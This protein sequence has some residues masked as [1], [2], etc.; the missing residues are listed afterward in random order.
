MIIDYY[1]FAASFLHI[2]FFVI[3]DCAP[4]DHDGLGGKVCATPPLDIHG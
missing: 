1:R 3:P 2:M 4:D